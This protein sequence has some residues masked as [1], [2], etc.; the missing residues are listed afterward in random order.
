MSW[1]HL[2]SDVQADLLVWFNSAAPDRSDLRM[3]EKLY[4][5]G[6][7]WAWDCPTCGERC[8]WADP[9]NPE[10]FQGV[11]QQD[12]VSHPVLRR[13]FYSPLTYSMQCDTCR[14]HPEASPALSRVGRG[15]PPC[16]DFGE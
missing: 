5:D 3:L 10:E 2:K 12:Y 15:K 8:Y 13:W 1:W 9:E 16:W 14:A 6:R 7:F 4:R 11:I